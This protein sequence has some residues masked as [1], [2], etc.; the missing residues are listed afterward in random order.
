MNAFEQAGK[1]PQ[2]GLESGTFQLWGSCA[3]RPLC[4]RLF[5]KG[6]PEVNFRFC[7]I[8]CYQLCASCYYLFLC[9]SILRNLLIVFYIYTCNYIYC[10]YFILFY[11]L[12]HAFPP[13]V[14]I[15][16]VYFWK[17][18]PDVL[19]LVMATL[20]PTQGPSP[21]WRLL[22]A[23]H[24]PAIQRRQSLLMKTMITV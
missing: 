14:P 13:I 8:I 11:F 4:Q 3:D 20:T 5:W 10:I 9:I 22:S 1:C 15:A 24:T 6:F 12:Q 7:T 16:G 2:Q 18:F 23:T 21:I 19:L 17:V